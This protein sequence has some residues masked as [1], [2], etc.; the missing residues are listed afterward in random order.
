[1]ATKLD[2]RDVNIS[3]NNIVMQCGVD[4]AGRGPL[5]GDVYAAAV[6]IDPNNPILG[7]KDSKQLT[8]KKRDTLYDEIIS[9]SLAYCITSS[10]VKEID[11]LNILQ[12]TLLAMKRAIEGLKITPSIALIDGNKTP[13]LR[14]PAQAIIKGDTKVESISAASILAKVTRDRSLLILDELYPEYGFAKHKGYGTAIHIAA[15]N[16]YGVLP[17]HRKSFAPIKFMC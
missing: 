4:E 2:I 11:T 3:V 8:S 15:I 13:D 1:M 7:L 16:K 14:I 10:S 17:I 12:A 9:K 6:I 5:A